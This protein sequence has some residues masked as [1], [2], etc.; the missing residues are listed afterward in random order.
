MFQETVSQATKLGVVSVPVGSVTLNCVNLDVKVREWSLKFSY[1][2]G[3]ECDGINGKHA[4]MLETKL[5]KKLTDPFL[6]PFTDALYIQ[7]AA[8]G[9]KV[10]IFCI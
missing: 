4:T 9:A 3:N 6:L 1:T 5:L 2:T 10:C 8:L 7:T